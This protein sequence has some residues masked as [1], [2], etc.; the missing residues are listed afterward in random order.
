MN[1]AVVKH[2]ARY[3]VYYSRTKSLL[4][5]SVQSCIE[6][7]G[8]TMDALLGNSRVGQTIDDVCKSR[9]ISEYCRRALATLEPLMVKCDV[10][11]VSG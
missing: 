8:V 3:G 2:V 9:F 5:T 11:N 4:G 6:R 10:L 1:L 7:F